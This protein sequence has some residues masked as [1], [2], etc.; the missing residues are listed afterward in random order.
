MSKKSC[1]PVLHV[2]A[3]YIMGIDFFRLAI[4]LNNCLENYAMNTERMGENG[5]AN[6]VVNGS[7]LFGDFVSL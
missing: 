6:L 2:I 7:S 4:S 1:T 3:M 5:S